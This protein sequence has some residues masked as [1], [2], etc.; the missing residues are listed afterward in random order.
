VPENL[1]LALDQRTCEHLAQRAELAFQGALK[2][3]ILAF[4]GYTVEHLEHALALATYRV[5]MRR[6]GEAPQVLPGSDRGVAAP[7][8]ENGA[9]PAC[10]PV[11]TGPGED[12][13]D[14][15][16]ALADGSGPVFVGNT[17]NGRRVP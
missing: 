6:L 16:E 8:Q 4:P 1:P 10:R 3:C 9:H 13:T 17:V 14:E 7:G 11:V 5:A 2:N 12:L 15:H